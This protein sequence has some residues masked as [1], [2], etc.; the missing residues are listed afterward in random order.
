MILIIR[1]YGDKYQV[2]SWSMHRIDTTTREGKSHLDQFDEEVVFN[3][4]I[5]QCQI[6]AD[7]MV[8]ADMVNKANLIDAARDEMNNAMR[9]IS[10]I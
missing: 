8:K 2:V 10:R 7:H 1:P 6:H 5:E 3:G 4:T 9:L